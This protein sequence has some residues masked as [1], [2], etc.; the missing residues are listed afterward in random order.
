M[1][2]PARART[3]ES[4]YWEQ[5]FAALSCTPEESERWMEGEVSRYVSEFGMNEETAWRT[6]ACNLA[7]FAGYY[8]ASAVK[9]LRRAFGI[10]PECFDA[11]EYRQ[12]KRK[13]MNDSGR[14]ATDS[15]V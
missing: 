15:P 8:G 4:S 3:L 6:I 11:P 10:F 5:F 7:Y 14:P 12:D 13:S 2:A 1:N 9:T